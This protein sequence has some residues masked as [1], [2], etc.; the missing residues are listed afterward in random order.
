MVGRLDEAA[1]V[2]ALAAASGALYVVGF[3]KRYDYGV[4]LARQILADVSG[5]NEFG[6]L[7]MVDS[8]CNG[9]DWTQNIEAP[10][11]VP[12]SGNLSPLTPTYPDACRTAEDRGRY[13]WLI[14]IFSHTV[15]LCHYLLDGEMVTQSATF[16]GDRALIATLQRDDLPITIRGARSTAHEWR[17]WT[18]FTFE[19]GEIEVRTP[20]P[21]RR[22]SSAM[23][24]V[25][26]PSSGRWVTE[27]HHAEPSWAFFQQARGF[28]E[29]LAGTA[30]LRTPASAAV[31]DVRI[32]QPIIE[33]AEI[34]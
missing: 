12:A 29:A 5:S 13:D 18:T 17:E 30:T 23:V 24:T 10:V 1:E 6:S 7:L 27:T 31:Q 25:L 3:M 33:I 8:I 34:H 16:H 11:R 19:R 20:T 4:D 9:G 14:N 22:H 28:V 21:L 15:N 26:K 2:T 32:M